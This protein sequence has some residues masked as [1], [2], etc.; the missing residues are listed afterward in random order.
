MSEGKH[1]RSPLGKFHLHAPWKRRDSEDEDD[2]APTADEKQPLA[3]SSPVCSSPQQANSPKKTAKVHVPVDSYAMENA[4]VTRVW[5]C[6]MPPAKKTMVHGVLMPT[7]GG[8]F[9]SV[10]IQKKRR[11]AIE[12]HSSDDDL[13]APSSPE[14]PP[15]LLRGD[16][17]EGVDGEEV[18][19]GNERVIVRI[20]KP[21]S[22]KDGSD[23]DSSQGGDH[24][25]ISTIGFHAVDEE[26]DT[27]VTN[28]ILGLDDVQILKSRGSHCEMKIGHGSDTQVRNVHF[29]SD[30]DAKSFQ[31]VLENL[32]KMKQRLTEQRVRDFRELSHVDQGGGGRIRLLI[33]IVSGINLPVADRTATDPYVIVRLGGS[34]EVHRTKPIYKTVN[35]IWTIDSGSLFLLDVTPEEFFGSAEGLSFILRDYDKISS[36]DTLGKVFVSQENLLNGDGDRVEFDLVESCSKN[37]KQPGRLVL[38]FR[39]AAEEDVLFMER[40]L[41]A[42]KAKISGVYGDETFVQPH[43]SSNKF[44]HREHRNVGT[45][46]QH[47]VK[48]GP[49][50]DRPE[51]ATKW[52]TEAELE[53]ESL[54]PSRKWIEAGSG[55]LGK[56]FVEVLGCDGLPN[57]DAGTVGG[58]K[59]DAFA[60]LV[61]EDSVMNT[62]VINDTLKPR[63]MPWTQRAFIFNV[64]HPS[65]DL[66]VG[67]LDYDSPAPMAA[68]DPIGRTEID[69]TN[70]LPGTEYTVYY[71][72]FTSATVKKRK[73]K[74]SIKLRIRL[75]LN[76]ERKA[77]LAGLHP[78][79]Q[80]YI[81]VA[82]YRDYKVVNFVIEGKYDIHVFDMDLLAE[83]VEELKETGLALVPILKNAAFLVVFWRG[84]HPLRLRVFRCPPLPASNDISLWNRFTRT[85]TILLPLHS[86]VAF[87]AAVF[88]VEDYN[89]FPSFLMFSIAWLFLATSGHVGVHP[90]PWR[91]PRSFADL[92][93]ALVSNT[94]RVKTIE[95]NQNL[96]ELQK[97]Q[98]EKD[99]AK[100]RLNEEAE[101][102]AREE[103][104]HEDAVGQLQAM[105]DGGEVD[106]RTKPGGLGGRVSVNPLKRESAAI[107]VDMSSSTANE[108]IFANILSNTVSNAAEPP[109][110]MSS[111]SHHQELRRLGG[112]LL[113]LLDSCLFD[114]RR[115]SYS[116]HP[117]GL[118]CA[119]GSSYCCVGLLGP[120][121]ETH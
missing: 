59:T 6:K 56:L 36:N 121:D 97:Y 112:V 55:E 78:P 85:T 65:N 66:M 11:F 49:D 89:L 35:P 67:V 58:G 62:E 22:A 95:P 68:H 73:P 32:I 43:V 15:T 40:L 115:L 31:Q 64:M 76:N 8:T 117:M 63:W 54:K 5:D 113:L 108:S 7:M 116:V 51:Q 107:H 20:L 2:D 72:L 1:N 79:P 90:S 111:G 53:T 23:N 93:R 102:K 42:Q 44:L 25:T 9:G 120:L 70:M 86:V 99:E 29:S 87:V 110:R 46:T 81:N 71:E 98:A 13:G 77:V 100:K 27:W 39:K 24:G 12:I 34:H 114:C 16:S 28:Y 41:S 38:R 61:F 96:Q 37:K 57:M 4:R 74:G 109:S 104:E 18:L 118:A 103:E 92:G 83:Y 45:Q 105:E 94:S 19:G 3:P 21:A 50:P 14:G 69:I 17:L 30:R 52:M 84:H 60:C 91:H 106:M 88:L 33:E 10:L 119:L 75:E 80:F 82:T 101:N 26:T 48:P 47:R